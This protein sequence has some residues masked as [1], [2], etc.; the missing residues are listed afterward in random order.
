MLHPAGPSVNANIDA[1]RIRYGKMLLSEV[2]A[3]AALANRSGTI[4]AKRAGTANIPFA[5]DA[6]ASFTTPSITIAG[7]GSLANPP[8]RLR[9]PAATRGAGAGSM[10]RA[11]IGD[12]VARERG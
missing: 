9:I 3:R 8:I 12:P 10:A 7:S 1:R 5:F 2:S 11:R 4:N 6:Q